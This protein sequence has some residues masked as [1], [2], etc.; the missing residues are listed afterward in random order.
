MVP[1]FNAIGV[2]M[3]RG[4]RHTGRRRLCGDRGRDWSG[5]PLNQ[6]MLRIANDH[7]NPGEK[8]RA[9]PC[10]HFDFGLCLV[11]L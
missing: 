7:Q 5:A 8:E 11:E 1:K 9:W 10:Q 2:L 3:R 4:D 6:G